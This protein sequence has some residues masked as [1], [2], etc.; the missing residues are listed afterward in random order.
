[1]AIIAVVIAAGMVMAFIV[2]LGFPRRRPGNPDKGYIRVDKKWIPI[3]EYR[4]HKR[5]KF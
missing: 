3:K 4:A 5:I 1:M 2:A